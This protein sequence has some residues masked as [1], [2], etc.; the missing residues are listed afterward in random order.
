M[1]KGTSRH[2]LAGRCFATDMMLA[3]LTS[4]GIWSARTGHYSFIH[5]LSLVTLVNIPVAIWQL[6][7]GRI[8]GQAIG[9]IAAFAS[10]LGA[11]AYAML[12]SRLP[13]QMFF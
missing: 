4:F 10:L 2:K 12:P 5:M 9:M 3:A 11:G 1:A 13:G 6:R 8:R 7:R